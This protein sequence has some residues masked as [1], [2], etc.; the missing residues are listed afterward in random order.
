MGRLWP[1]VIRRVHGHSMVPVLPPGTL[2][3]G[4]TWFWRLQPNDVVIF[5]R[6]GKEMLKR[7]ERIERD[8]LFLLGDH[9]EASTDSRHFGLIP[10]TAVTA[11]VI[12]P[13]SPR[14]SL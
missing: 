4:L 12:Y 3:W 5:V 11:K 9:V 6:D 8:S 2:V 10:K 1:F 13:R 7:I 14:P